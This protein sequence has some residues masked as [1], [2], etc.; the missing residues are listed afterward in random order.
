L[1]PSSTISQPGSLDGASGRLRPSERLVVFIFIQ[2]IRIDDIISPQSFAPE[3]PRDSIERTEHKTSD[4][5]H[6]ESGQESERA[7]REGPRTV[8]RKSSKQPEGRKQRIENGAQ[9]VC[10]TY[11]GRQR[12][13]M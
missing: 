11:S 9:D 10:H 7:S 3:I 4:G 8:G 6:C 5:E 13:R 12:K 1:K 2:D